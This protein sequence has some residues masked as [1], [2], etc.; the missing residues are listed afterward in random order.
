MKLIKTLALSVFAS[1]V[2]MTAAMTPAAY[3]SGSYYGAIAVDRSTGETYVAIDVWG[4]AYGAQFAALKQCGERSSCAAIQ[5]FSQCGAVAYSP[6]A[7]NWTWGAGS[8]LQAAEGQAL[9]YTDSILKREA[10][11]TY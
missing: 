4:G 10:C 5:S 1:G 8:D 3:A 2:A 11:N 6:G 9:H 7:Q